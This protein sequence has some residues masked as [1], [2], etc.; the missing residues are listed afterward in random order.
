MHGV[1]E[2]CRRDA[3]AVPGVHLDVDEPRDEE[4]SWFVDLRVESHQV[5]VEWRPGRGFG[6]TA[7]TDPHDYGT[8]P[9][10]LLGTVD[11]AAARVVELLRADRAN[12]S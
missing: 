11:E 10:E 7:L 12:S 5:N 2:L 9:D 8:G 1:E 4:G 3:D 6:I